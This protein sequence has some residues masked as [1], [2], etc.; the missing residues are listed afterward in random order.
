[1]YFLDDY[2]EKLYAFNCPY[3]GHDSGI[4]DLEDSSI[5]RFSPLGKP[6]KIYQQT[7]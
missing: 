3:G 6:S 2:P 5:T 4:Y 7:F 1:M